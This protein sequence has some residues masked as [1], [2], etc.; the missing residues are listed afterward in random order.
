[1]WEMTSGIRCGVRCLGK[2]TAKAFVSSLTKLA[3]RKEPGTENNMLG[4]KRRIHTKGHIAN[5]ARAGVLD[6]RHSLKLKRRVV[7][8]EDLRR[9]L[10]RA[11]AGINKLLDKDLAIHSVRLLAEDGAEDDGHTIET[12]LDVDGLLLAVVDG[13]DLASL[14]DALRCLFGCVLGR[15]LLQ[16][17]MLSICVLEGCR[18]G[19]A[20][21]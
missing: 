7:A 11:T 17:V 20:L 21:E 16:L 19:I 14:T 15:L 8:E 18:H 4:P 2:S 12:G 3:R 6:S 9:I 13:H 10:D 1:M 5:L